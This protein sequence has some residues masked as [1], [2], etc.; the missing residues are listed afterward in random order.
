MTLFPSSISEITF[1]F[2][3]GGSSLP[4]KLF[5]PA[6]TG[7][8]GLAF[9]IS[10]VIRKPLILTIIK[11]LKHKVP[12]GLGNSMPDR[13]FPPK[14][15]TIITAVAGLVLLGDAVTH[16]IMAIS[17]PTGTFL[18]MS[19][20]VTIAVVVILFGFRWIVGRSGLRH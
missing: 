11:A 6:L 12:E 7:I 16:I 9:L 10:A 5:R 3:L 15:M 1:S 19:R 4:F 14:K 20:V 2:L 13:G 18:L 8:I 17:L